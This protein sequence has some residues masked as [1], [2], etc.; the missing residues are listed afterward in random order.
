MIGD[1]TIHV[2]FAAVVA[3]LFIALGKIHEIY[4]LSA[5]L[6]FKSQI[7]TVAIT[8][9]LVFLFLTAIGF[10]MK[11][12]GNFSRGTVLCFATSGLVALVMIAARG[13]WRIFLADGLAVRQFSNRK[14]GLI[15]EQLFVDQPGLL[16]MLARH[17]FQPVQQFILSADRN[18]TKHQQKVIAQAVSSLE[19]LG[20]SM[21]K[22]LSSPLISN[23]GGN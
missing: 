4:T 22:K 19:R 3:A 11:V 10:V 20:I 21:S 7:R 14:V 23:I 2:G 13:G 5:L 1:I 18:N 17:G 16:G 6:N 12:G 15:A 9:T 8:W